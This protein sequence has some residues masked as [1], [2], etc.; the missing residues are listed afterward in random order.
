MKVLIIGSKGFIGQHA[1][2]FYH[3]KA[4]KVW[5]CDVVVDYTATDYWLIDA[6]NSN[7]EHIF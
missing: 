1:M 5:G 3:D 6:S 7:F 2:A 4:D